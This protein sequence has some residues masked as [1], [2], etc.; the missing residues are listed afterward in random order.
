MVETISSC[1]ESN[2]VVAMKRIANVLL[3]IVV[4]GGIGIA[5]YFLVSEAAQDTPPRPLADQA[6]T[7]NGRPTTCSELFRHACDFNLQSEYN[8]W[9][10]G[11]E[12]FV[13][14]SA[15]GSYAED[16]GFVATAKLS[17]QA[18]GLSRTPGKTFLEFIDLARLDQP[19]ASSAQLFPFWN[20]TRQDL[21]PQG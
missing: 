14:S 18:C 15:L 19:D 9:G 16:I 4:V 21:C 2:G 13:T 17:L 10:D 7:I 3:I 8:M 1:P 12:S 20:R 5:L 11:V 6:F